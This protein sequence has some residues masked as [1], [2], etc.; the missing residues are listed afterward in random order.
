V[1]SQRKFLGFSFTAGKPRRRIA[2]QAL[3][4]FKSRV[5]N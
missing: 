4:Q 1:P 5:R 2:S 3:A